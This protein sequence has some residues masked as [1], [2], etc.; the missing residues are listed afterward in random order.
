MLPLDVGGLGFKVIVFSSNR[1][2]L[3]TEVLGKGFI[4]RFALVT[5]GRDKVGAIGFCSDTTA[6]KGGIG[7][8]GFRIFL[9]DTIALN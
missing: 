3:E 7:S 6:E 2:L 1:D 5:R 9:W 4:T 8:F